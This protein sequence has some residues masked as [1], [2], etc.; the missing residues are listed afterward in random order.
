MK[1][2]KKNEI[3]NTIGEVLK[4]QEKIPAIKPKTDKTRKTEIIL[5]RK[6]SDR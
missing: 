4:N 3:D 1:P 6:D 5:I 2:T